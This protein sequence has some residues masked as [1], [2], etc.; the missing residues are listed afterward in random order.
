MTAKPQNHLYFYNWTDYIAPNT[1][2]NFEKQTGIKVTYDVFDSNEMLDG[3][4]MAGNTGFDLVVPSDNFLA[5]QLHYNIYQPLDKNRL[6]HYSN[7]DKKLLEM[8][9]IHDPGNRYGIPYLWQTTGIGINTTKV[10]Q[11]LGDNAPLDSWDLLFKLE[12]IKKLHRCGIAFLD[13][14]SEI[15]PTV[16][17][18]LGKSPTTA[19]KKDYLQANELLLAIRPYVTYFHSSKYINDLASGD[20]CVAIA[21]SGDI[22]QAKNAAKNANKPFDIDYTVPK[23]GAL[24]SFDLLAIPKQA[25]NMDE[26]YQFLNYLLAPNVIADIS[27]HIFYPNA[28]KASKP[29]LNNDVINNSAIYP[30]KSIMDRLFT[31]TELPPK[32]DRFIVR[33]WTKVLTGY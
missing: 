28:N 6:S 17:K 23:E 4:L 9:E 15:Y 33:L 20:I 8:L 13:A 27:N 32:T 10:K 7:L 25:K 30:P 16:L 22:M 21:W 2:K 18:Y 31:V 11:I 1:I 14:P 5:R 19:T 12:N 3:K 24:I 26:T 29:F